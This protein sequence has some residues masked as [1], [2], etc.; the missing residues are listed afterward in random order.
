MFVMERGKFQMA[1]GV[2]YCKDKP[3]KIDRT[4][5]LNT[6]VGRIAVGKKAENGELEILAYSD[7]ASN[8]AV[9]RKLAKEKN[10][11]YIR[12]LDNGGVTAID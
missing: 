6:Y 12:S 10:A 8:S 1:E 3:I 11:L 5:W 9:L 2:V 4:V 7:D